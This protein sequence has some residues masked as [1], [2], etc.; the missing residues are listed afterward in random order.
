MTL[1][2][3][4]I[5]VGP[6]NLSLACLMEPAG[7]LNAVFL[8]KR[9]AFSW[10]QGM[11]LPDAKIQVSHVKDLVT[12][13]D[14]TNPYSFMSYLKE[15]GRLY[16]FVNARFET[17]MRREFEDYLA[18]AFRKNTLVRPGHGVTSVKFDGDLIVGTEH[19]AF[20]SRSIS[21][22]V[23]RVPALPDCLDRLDGPNMVHS[24]GYMDTMP[25]V[26]D[27]TICVVGGGQ[28]GAEICLDLLKRDP[29]NAP[30]KIIWSTR[31]S[32]FDPIDDSP[33][34]NELFT[35]QHSEAHFQRD[36]LSQRAALKQ[37]KLASDGISAS[38]LEEV[39]QSLYMHRF[40]TRSGLEA[41]LVSSVTLTAV[42]RQSDGSINLSFR[43]NNPGQGKLHHVQCDVVVLCTGYRSSPLSFLDD[44]KG[45]FDMVG[46]EPKVREDFS[47]VWDGPED[48]KI[49][50]QN[51]SHLQRGIADPNLSL[52]AWR[53]QVIMDSVQG[54]PARNTAQE[55]SFLSLDQA[56]QSSMN[57]VLGR[58]AEN[59]RALT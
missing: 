50:L 46:D 26:K 13:A 14:P 5:G 48:R 6:F 38:T 37:F 55:P 54:K 4:G 52:N 31:R 49:Y 45:R 23:G 35:P 10:H 12:M 7:D 29:E 20:S 44:L 51:A 56:G 3:V 36:A 1:D 2:C 58:S 27:K 47:V 18:W 57:A 9:S 24:S 21:I 53:N 22:G 28:S 41:D 32:N 43:P 25:D 11:Q 59:I 42:N 17:V 19:D 30:R 40:V 16:H 34:A 15:H 8:E 39:Y 33:F